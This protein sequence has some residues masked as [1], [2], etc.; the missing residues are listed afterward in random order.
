ML[1]SVSYSQARCILREGVCPV[2]EI[3]ISYPSLR[4]V[5]KETCDLPASVVRFNQTYRTVAENLMLWAKDV[6]YKAVLAD[7]AGA[8]PLAFY[9]FDRRMVTCTIEIAMPAGMD[10]FDTDSEP[11]M[12]PVTRNLRMHSRRGEM[13]EKSVAARDLWRWPDLTLGRK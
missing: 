9:R 4:S 11:F 12:I 3:S 8:G 13:P 1:F 7:F 5:E 2:L 6:P 10:G